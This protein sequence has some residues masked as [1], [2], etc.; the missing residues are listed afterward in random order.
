MAKTKKTKKAPVKKSAKAKKKPQQKKPSKPLK[1]SGKSKGKNTMPDPDLAPECPQEEKPAT[2]KGKKKIIPVVTEPVRETEKPQE[3]PVEEAKPEPPREPFTRKHLIE[4]VKKHQLPFIE[5][6]TNEEMIIMLKSVQQR[7][8]SIVIPDTI[9]PDTEQSAENTMTPGMS[10]RDRLL[11]ELKKANVQSVRDN[12]NEKELQ[13]LYE[14]VNMINPGTLPAIDPAQQNAPAAQQ[15]ATA[16]SIT[17]TAENIDQVANQLKI[18]QP[19]N[20][21]H[22]IPQYNNGLAN[23][24]IKP[25]REII[26]TS[27]AE[28]TYKNIQIFGSEI[29]KNIGRHWRKMTIAEIEDTF[30]KGSA[31]PYSVS[32]MRH[33]IDADKARICITHDNQTFLF[34]ENDWIQIEP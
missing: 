9:A 18:A 12:M 20:Q 28:G 14:A 22:Q 2:K 10:Y 11:F 34:P 1:K 16:E 24:D 7:D 23:S 13:T 19:V 6:L 31:I 30:I 27:T 17:V 5:S 32:V 33:S 29:L 26:D 21:T 8:P 25:D 3:Q 15:G 4:L